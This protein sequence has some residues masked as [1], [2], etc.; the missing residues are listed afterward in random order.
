MKKMAGILIACAVFA[1]LKANV[2]VHA[3]STIGLN[4]TLTKDILAQQSDFVVPASMT[5]T[6]NALKTVLAQQPY[7]DE[8]L[9]GENFSSNGITTSVHISW[10]QTKQ[11]SVVLDN[12][13]H[14]VLAELIKP[15]MSDF[16]KEF[17]IHNWIVNHVAYDNTLT[18]YTP[19]DAMMENSA[20][21]QG[22]ATLAYRMLTFAGIPTQLVVG[23]AGGEAH[24]WNEVKV[25]G[26]WYQLDVT[27]DD[28]VNKKPGE[29]DYTYYNLTDAELAADHVWN[30]SGHPVATTNFATAVE[31]VE[32]SHKDAAMNQIALATGVTA[33]LDSPTVTSTNLSS[34]VQN[35]INQKKTVFTLKYK[36]ASSIVTLAMNQL[37]LTGFTNLAYSISPSRESGYQLIT[38]SVSF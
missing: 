30:H 15:G 27:W 19:Y 36:G 24:L 17:V 11:Q 32:K 4:S 8:L 25:G 35:E 3:Q 22:I 14:A 37:N 34:T 20:V 9:T 1:A 23:T 29:V 31:S 21:C 13:I 16:G 7:M 2:A 10:Q 5:K 6:E 12:Q 28:P 33:E 26:K 18:R 38:V